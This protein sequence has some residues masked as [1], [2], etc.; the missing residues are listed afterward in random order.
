[1]YSMQLAD[2]DRLSG[3]KCICMAFRIFILLSLFLL[4]LPPPH[5]LLLLPLIPL[6][7]PFLVHAAVA[8]T[9]KVLFILCEFGN[10]AK[11]LTKR[12]LLLCLPFPH[13]H[14]WL[15]IEINDIEPSAEVGH[16]RLSWFSKAKKPTDSQI[17]FVYLSLSL[18]HRLNIFH[19]Q[20]L[21]FQQRRRED[22]SDAV[23]QAKLKNDKF[24]RLTCMV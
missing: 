11:T 19:L 18:E 9:V 1:M 8:T 4:F 21:T 22:E 15:K 10:T 3:L 6:S 24:Q 14:T 12:I 17:R 5:L 16:F 23:K 20:K 7:A 2:N 13:T